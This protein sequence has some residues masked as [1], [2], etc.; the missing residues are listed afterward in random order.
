MKFKNYS[1]FL[2]YLSIKSPRDNF[3]VLFKNF[4]KLPSAFNRWNKEYLNQSGHVCFKDVFYVSDLYSNEFNHHP[5]IIV[6]NKIDLMIHQFKI[7][8]LDRKYQINPV[9]DE[10]KCFIDDYIFIN[11]KFFKKKVTEIIYLQNYNKMILVNVFENI[12][13]SNSF[14]DK[15]EVEIGYISS[16]AG[17][18]FLKSIKNEKFNVLE[19]NILKNIC[20][21]LKSKYAIDLY[22]Q[23]DN[24]LF[25]QNLRDVFIQKKME[26][27]LFYINK[28]LKTYDFSYIYLINLINFRNE[29]NNVSS[30]QLSFR[31]KIFKFVIFNI[32][33][34]FL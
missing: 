34:Y 8:D 28:F 29:A 17:I 26:E 2:K 13:A 18:D 20:L 19:T 14:I 30:Y 6:G 1:Y 31:Q 23:I 12:L 27:P 24:P 5:A 32:Y 33:K 3:N 16:L 15:V 11:F 10:H 22:D 21:N 7:F 25:F 9:L 4:N